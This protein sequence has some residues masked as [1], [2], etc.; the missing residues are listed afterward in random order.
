MRVTTTVGPGMG[1]AGVAWAGMGPATLRKV[2]FYVNPPDL[3]LSH[4]K[5]S[6]TGCGA[7]S[8]TSQDAPFPVVG[9]CLFSH[10]N[11]PILPPHPGVPVIPAHGVLFMPVAQ[12]ILTLRISS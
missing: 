10:L 8:Q 2:F 6:C 4:P 5:T 1:R 12:I 9:V 11:V 3:I 7:C